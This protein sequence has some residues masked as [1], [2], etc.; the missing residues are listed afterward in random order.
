MGL[1]LNRL[2]LIELRQI[3]GKAFLFYYNKYTFPH[4]TQYSLILSN[5]L[6]LYS[7]KM[8]IGYIV[9]KMEIGYIIYRV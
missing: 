1:V 6:P 8:E 2:R 3:T 9:Y 4:K 5:N 7:N